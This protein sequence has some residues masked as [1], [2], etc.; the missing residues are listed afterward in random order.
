MKKIVFLSLTII[1]IIASC[2]KQE[3]K[4][5]Q[6]A[7]QFIQ[8]QRVSG[9]SVKILFPGEYT[10]SNIE[11]YSEGHRLSVGL[12]KRDTMIINN[13]VGSTYT[14]DGNRLEE[15]L[16]YNQNSKIV[17][18]KIKHIIELRNDTLI[19]SYP[20]DDNWE[21]IKSGYSIEKHIRVK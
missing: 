1:L 13:Y 11:I 20:C 5:P 8:W 7:W 21:L 16:L 3:S 10:G 17:G 9:D 18:K 19:D 2:A 14:L 12:F 6:G 4:F 15:I